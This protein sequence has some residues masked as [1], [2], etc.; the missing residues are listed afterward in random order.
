[1]HICI[2]YHYQQATHFG[3]AS[4]ERIVKMKREMVVE[5]GV[6]TAVLTSSANAL[7]REAQR[8][9]HGRA[10]VGAAVGGGVGALVGSFKGPLAVVICACLLAL[11]GYYI[12][13][14]LDRR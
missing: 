2:A 9:G 12:G 14:R 8:K 10:T 11:A 5:N 7:V 3:V 1:M 13:R 4:Q 6:G